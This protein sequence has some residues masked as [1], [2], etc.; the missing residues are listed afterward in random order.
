MT[1]ALTLKLRCHSRNLF[2]ANYCTRSWHCG[3]AMLKQPGTLRTNINILIVW[4][5]NTNTQIALL[6]YGKTI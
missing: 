6:I 3:I 2:K 4:K 5:K 1:D